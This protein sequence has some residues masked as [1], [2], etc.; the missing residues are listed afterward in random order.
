[1]GSDFAGTVTATGSGVTAVQPGDQVYGIAPL[2]PSGAFA[3]AV[4]VP[5]S[6]LALM[7]AALSFEQDA[8]VATPAVM[9]QAG[10]IDRARLRAGQRVFVDGAT[11]GVGEAGAPA[12]K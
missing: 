9:A 7:P 6:H 11:G 8:A 2:G 12:P 4:I 5:S 3:Q 10:L 1:M